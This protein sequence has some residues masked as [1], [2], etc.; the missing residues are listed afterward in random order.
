MI[1]VVLVS[2]SEVE[3]VSFSL[4]K[5]KKKKPVKSYCCFFLNCLVTLPEWNTHSS[6]VPRVPTCAQPQPL[7]ASCTQS[8]FVMIDDPALIHLY[9]PESVVYS[10]CSHL[11][12]YISWVLTR[13]VTCLHHFSTIEKSFA[14]PNPLCSADSSLPPHPQP[15][16]LLICFLSA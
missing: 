3:N 9:H 1:L 15:L 5:K 12:F 10:L 7:S 16:Q 8:A 4:F 11:A 14:A 6:H 13:I 2:Y